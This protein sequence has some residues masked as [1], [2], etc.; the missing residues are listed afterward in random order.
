MSSETLHVPRDV[1]SQEARLLHNAI[2]AEIIARRG[3]SLSAVNVCSSGAF[4]D[5]TD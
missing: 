3:A 1:L 4:A 2:S 5:G